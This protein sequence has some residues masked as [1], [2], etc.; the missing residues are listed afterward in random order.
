MVGIKPA[1]ATNP[2]SLA[3]PPLC[4]TANG[5]ATVAIAVPSIEV[6]SHPTSSWKFRL[7]S[8]P[9]SRAHRLTR[10]L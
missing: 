8:G 4:S 1:A 10:R 2:T 6:T 7:A 5:T 9:R 3:D